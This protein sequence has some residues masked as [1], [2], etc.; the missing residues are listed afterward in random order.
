MSDEKDRVKPEQAEVND[1][2]GADVLGAA[3]GVASGVA[4]RLRS[5]ISAVRDVHAA[6][7][8]H[9][10]ARGHLR[11]LTEALEADEATLARREEVEADYEGIVAEQGAVVAEASEEIARQEDAV[12]R[13][14]SEADEL[15]QQ[16]AQMRTEHEREIRPYKKLL[17]TARGRSEEANRAVGEAKR[18]VRGAEG[19]VKD[20]TERREQSISSA[21]R[22]VDSSQ[23]RLRKVQEEL[24]RAQG[25]NADPSA[26]R[27]LHDEVTTELAHVESAR[28]E[29]GVVT[30]DAQA[31]VDAAQTHLWTQKQSLEEAQ[32]EADEAKGEYDERKREHDE[33]LAREQQ[34]EKGLEDRIESLRNGANEAKAAHDEAAERHDA[35]QALLEEAESV[36]A[37]P[38]ETVRLR[39]SV[40]Q[41]RGLVARQQAEVD[42]LAEGERSL[43]TS[44]RGTRLALL[45]AVVGV[46]V[47]LAVVIAL[48]VTA[49]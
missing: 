29:V 37:T 4:E 28:E 5:G 32:R 45:A 41:Q 49:G 20:A 13:L 12:K 35:A 3:R 8:R 46:V 27:Q 6:A 48:V 40:E 9:S 24:K 30:R 2:R 17:E 11:E 25:S 44:T 21:N 39:Q 31:S 23:A 7:K 16:L 10:S 19:Q 42:S 33:I 34:E 18:A 43:R 14:E 26:L 1:D 36:H 38:E 22:A 47:L 15:D